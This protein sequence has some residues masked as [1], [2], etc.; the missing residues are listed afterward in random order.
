MNKNKLPEHMYEHI[1]EEIAADYLAYLT[2]FDDQA[3]IIRR[4]HDLYVLDRVLPRFPNLTR[5]TAAVEPEVAARAR[6]LDFVDTDRHVSNNSNN[7][8]VTNLRTPAVNLLLSPTF[9]TQW[10]EKGN[11]YRELEGYRITQVLMQNIVAHSIRPDSFCLGYV[12]PWSIDRRCSDIGRLPPLLSN[13]KRF[14]ADIADTFA[15]GSHNIP[16]KFRED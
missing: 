7:N 16:V 6:P 15:L 1:L 12:H 11:R 14:K 3:K 5:F 8:K 2:I 10:V 9:R 13:I 4:K